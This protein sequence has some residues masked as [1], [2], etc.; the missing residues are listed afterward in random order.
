MLFRRKAVQEEPCQLQVRVT[1]LPSHMFMAIVAPGKS[2]WWVP[3]DGSGMFR[4]FMSGERASLKGAHVRNC[5]KH[6]GSGME[7]QWVHFQM[8]SPWHP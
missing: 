6:F 3:L 1:L 7:F 8:L 4:L 5:T 2:D